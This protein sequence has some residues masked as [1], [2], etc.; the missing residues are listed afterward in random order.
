MGYGRRTHL[1]VKLESIDKVIKKISRQLKRAMKEISHI[2]SSPYPH[3]L[4]V[5]FQ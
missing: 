4:T 1:L 3:T 5:A 2:L